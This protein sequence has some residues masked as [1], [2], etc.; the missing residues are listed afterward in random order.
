MSRKLL[1]VAADIVQAQVSTNTMSS[2]EIVSSLKNLFNTLQAMQKSETEGTFLE[3][4]MQSEEIWAGERA[5]AID[6]KSSIQDDRIICLECSAEMKQLTAKHLH[7]HALSPRE[8]KQKWG[9]PLKQPLSAKSLTK[10]RSK[11]AKKRGLPANLIKFQEAK[12]RKKEDRT[13]GEIDQ[14]AGMNESR[15]EPMVESKRSRKKNSE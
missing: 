8:Y 14:E 15:P 1:E 9:F 5:P 6:P 2:E 4:A 10:A 7:S 11:A 13:A 12:K 3:E